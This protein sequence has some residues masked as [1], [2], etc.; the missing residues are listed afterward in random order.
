MGQHF[1]VSRQVSLAPGASVVVPLHV[2]EP[3]VN[4]TA[5]F[6]GKISAAGAVTAQPILTS[7]LEG[8]DSQI[9]VNDSTSTALSAGSNSFLKLRQQ[10]QGEVRPPSQGKMPDGVI[11]FASAIKFTNTGA[12]QEQFNVLLCAAPAAY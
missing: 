6:S 4:F 2:S 7:S 12:S 11:S 3:Y 10:T 1:F 9:E 8:T 5:W